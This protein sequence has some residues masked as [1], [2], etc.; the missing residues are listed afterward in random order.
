MLTKFR[1]TVLTRFIL[2]SIIFTVL[3]S[4][5]PIDT[6]IWMHYLDANKAA[7]EKARRQLH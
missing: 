1:L 6:A 3:P 4:S 7:G 5:G 2:T